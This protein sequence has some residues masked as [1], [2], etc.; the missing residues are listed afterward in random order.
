MARCGPQARLRIV[1]SDVASGRRRSVEDGDLLER[2]LGQ[3][4]YLCIGRGVANG[5]QEERPLVLGPSEDLLEEAHGRRRMR[6][7]GEPGGM[8][9][10]EQEADRDPDR[11]ADV[12]VL[13]L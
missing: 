3:V 9:R 6:Q 4:R 12:V 7:R 10:S 1:P 8:E 5:N 11:L 2:L 13:A